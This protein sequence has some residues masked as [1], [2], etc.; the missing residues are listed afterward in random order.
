MTTPV[1][2]GNFFDASAGT[3]AT[4]NMN[5]P[6]NGVAVCGHLRIA[7]VSAVTW[8]N[9]SERYD[10]VG[11]E[12]VAYSGADY[13]ATAAETG[14]TFTVTFASASVRALSIAVFR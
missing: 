10:S 12:G 2:T 8:T 11:V 9:A 5:L 14:R 1:S 13:T 6:L 4:L 7:G 3:T